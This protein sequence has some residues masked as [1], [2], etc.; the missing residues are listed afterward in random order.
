ML[1]G[2]CALMRAV[3]AIAAAARAEQQHRGQADP[4]AD[5]M[6]HDAAGEVVELRAGQRP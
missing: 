4:A 6:H 5:R 2:G 3:L 1:D